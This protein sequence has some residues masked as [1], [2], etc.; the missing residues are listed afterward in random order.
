MGRKASSSDSGN[1]TF[2]I[3]PPAPAAVL[4]VDADDESDIDSGHDNVVTPTMTPMTSSSTALP[5]TP[6]TV[7]AALPATAAPLSGPLAASITGLWRL[8]E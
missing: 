1:L 4:E 3:P 7:A 5:A 6:A 2:C 8:E